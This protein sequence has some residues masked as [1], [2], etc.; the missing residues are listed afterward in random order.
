MA[1]EIALNKAKY[2][3]AIMIYFG[4]NIFHKPLK[5]AMDGMESGV[6]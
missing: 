6:K 4:S 5:S 1:L 3:C 2:I